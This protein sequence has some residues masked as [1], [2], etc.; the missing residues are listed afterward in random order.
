MFNCFRA[1]VEIP[2]SEKSAVIVKKLGIF[3]LHLFMFFRN[4]TSKNVKSHVFGIFKKVKK[5]ILELWHQIRN[6]RQ[7]KERI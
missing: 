2:R 7:D 1:V 6:A 3:G 5:R 4:V